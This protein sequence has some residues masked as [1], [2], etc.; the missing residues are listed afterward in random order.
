ME[1][2]VINFSVLCVMLNLLLKGISS[3][4][5]HLHVFSLQPIYRE[6]SDTFKF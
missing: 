6:T 1:I 3:K 5:S 2:K 4:W